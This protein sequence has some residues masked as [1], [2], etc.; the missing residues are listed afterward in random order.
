[1][2]YWF[3]SCDITIMWYILLKLSVVQPYNRKNKC[4][5]YM[6]NANIKMREHFISDVYE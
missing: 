3:C 5:V 6:K 1:M 4:Y 2:V